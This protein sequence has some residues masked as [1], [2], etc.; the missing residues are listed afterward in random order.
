MDANSLAR[1]RELKNKPTD[2]PIENG[3]APLDP[4]IFFTQLSGNKTESVSVENDIFSNAK[5]PIET[6]SDILSEDDLFSSV[7]NIEINQSYNLEEEVKAEQS[8]IDDLRSKLQATQLIDPKATVKQDIVGEK[9]YVNGSSTYVIDQP[10]KPSQVVKKARKAIKKSEHNDKE[11]EGVD[12][13]ELL[14]IKLFLQK[15]KK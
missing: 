13:Y 10:D 2:Q 7:Q 6:N 15:I 4:S 3:P 1:L 12:N 14:L 11:Y 9:T 8:V 5:P